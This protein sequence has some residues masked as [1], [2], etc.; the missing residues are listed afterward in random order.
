MQNPRISIM[1]RAYKIHVDLSDALKADTFHVATYTRYGIPYAVTD[2]WNL[3]W[4]IQTKDKRK[5][6]KSQFLSAIFDIG[7]IF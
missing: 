3:K 4:L 1:Q 2:I 6:S 5:T 7:S